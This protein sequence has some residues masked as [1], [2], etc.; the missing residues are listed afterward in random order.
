MNPAILLFA[1]AMAVISGLVTGVAPARRAGAVDLLSGLRGTP[2]GSNASPAAT[3]TFRLIVTQLALSLLLLVVAGAFI[4]SFRKLESIDLGFRPEGLFQVD[5]DWERSPLSTNELLGVASAIVDDLRHIPGVADAGMSVPGVFGESTWQTSVSL[6]ESRDTLLVPITAAAPG[7]L[8]ALGIQFPRGQDFG[9]EDVAGSRA[10][11]ILSEALARKL[12]PAANPVGHDVRLYGAQSPVRVIGVASDIHLRDVLA[13][14]PA[15]I[16]VPFRQGRGDIARSVTWTVRS[17]LPPTILTKNV[18]RIVHA[19]S[20]AS[21]V[22]VRA[23]TDL[24][25][26]SVFL[27]RTMAWLTAIFGLL[28]L[29]LAVVGTYGIV[30]YNAERRMPEI[31]LRLAL[32]ATPS[33][34]CW[35]MC[36]SSIKPITIGAL[37]GCAASI[38]ALRVIS[39]Y[40]QGIFASAPVA[41]ALAVLVLMSTATLACLVPALRASKADPLQALRS[42]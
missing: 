29:G 39:A 11:A 1:L 12:F 3:R 17:A 28:G 25:G 15:L 23:V 8:S 19:R 26:Q 36:A 37:L 40:F 30:S 27:E 18:E 9:P 10:V 38:G 24:V 42:E 21:T 13:P 22:V 16:Y 34:M 20:P 32:G 14:P 6:P 33:G 31:G 2:A 35:K 7:Y 5:T 4:E 41:V